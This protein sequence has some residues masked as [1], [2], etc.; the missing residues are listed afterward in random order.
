MTAEAEPQ[1]RRL[2]PRRPRS[3]GVSMA[4]GARRHGRDGPPAARGTTL[5][6]VMTIRGDEDEDEDEDE[7]QSYPVVVG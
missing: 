4:T 6:I 1:T 3:D 5:A 2:H 7:A